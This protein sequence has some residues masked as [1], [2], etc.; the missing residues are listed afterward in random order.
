MMLVFHGH[1]GGAGRSAAV[2]NIAP[3]LSSQGYRVLVVDFDLEAPGI[4]RFYGLDDEDTR[5][6]GVVELVER[7][8][9]AM[10]GG[11]P[12]SESL[13]PAMLLEPRLPAM[14]LPTGE[15]LSPEAVRERIFGARTIGVET[16]MEAWVKVLP[17]G[18]IDADFRRRVARLHWDELYAQPAWRA[19]FG[20]FKQALTGLADLVVVDVRAGVTDMGA[21]CL[22]AL[23]DRAILLT[24]PTWQG[25]DGTIQTADALAQAGAAAARHG[26]V[27]VASR[28][29]ADADR[30][31]LG[32][33]LT[34]ARQR[35]AASGRLGLWTETAGA[36][37]PRAA[38]EAMV[39][40]FQLPEVPVHAVGEP[41]V[42]LRQL[43]RGIQRDPLADAY[44]R[45]GGTIRR[46]VA[47][48]RRDAARL[49]VLGDADAIRARI[50]TAR[51]E[52]QFEELGLLWVRLAEVLL[53]P[54][55]EDQAA[56]EARKAGERGA[57]H[58]GGLGDVA[59]EVRGWTCAGRAL[60]VLG[61]TAA[62]VEAMS[63]AVEAAPSTDAEMRGL[64]LRWQGQ[65][66]LA[67]G[68][69]RDA[70]GAFQAAVSLLPSPSVD[71]A[72]AW[73]G[74]AEAQKAVGRFD[75]EIESRTRCLEL[76]E[77]SAAADPALRVTARYNL[78]WSGSPRWTHPEASRLADEALAIAR[79]LR[80]PLLIGMAENALGNFGPTDARVLYRERAVDSLRLAVPTPHAPLGA[81]LN[82]LAR[83][84][85]DAARKQALFR[86]ASRTWA[87]ARSAGRFGAVI[88][89][90]NAVRV[91]AD[92][93]TALA[94]FDE[95]WRRYAGAEVVPWQYRQYL[96]ET[97]LL[98]AKRDGI[99]PHDRATLLARA[100]E[101]LDTLDPRD[102]E[103]D[104]RLAALTALPTP[105]RPPAPAVRPRVPAP[106]VRRKP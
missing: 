21:L 66:L 30:T 86:E 20:W 44:A 38:A 64:A 102:A 98:L 55:V 34:R 75:E 103:L 73:G 1:K 14:K 10:R 6:G 79:P 94:S 54:P 47:E 60:L 81:A 24:P 50:E 106:T 8:D 51:R 72:Y 90:C 91:L 9:A 37:D 87:R 33:W 96:A 82:N 84:I 67:H 63:R 32:A 83:H 40:G 46:W 5:N 43:E 19:F 26:L 4:H 36:A 70:L 48:S 31:E 23:A 77:A 101:M 42:A 16:P 25:L 11:A 71:L 88:P 56:A 104:A 41:L 3:V 100:H 95:V 52:R 105:A 69:W 74:L 99:S 18:R 59:T 93:P 12:F 13:D 57:V 78:A 15:E 76:A 92:L 65:A 49:Q 22:F 2:A 68:A 35:V 89:E 27:F 28:V 39:E 85:K 45:L 80:D 61:E 97:A 17:A 29:S 62:A 7:Y 53:T 58:A